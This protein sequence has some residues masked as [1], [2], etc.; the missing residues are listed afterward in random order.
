MCHPLHA[1]E[2]ARI[3]RFKAGLVERKPAK[4][5]TRRDDFG[6][7]FRPQITVACQSPT[8]RC[9]LLYIADA[10]QRRET[11]RD[12]CS[13]YGFNFNRVSA[14]KHLPP[15]LRHRANEG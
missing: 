12:I 13:P 15:K 2:V 11:L 7:G 14:A 10:R 6:S 1:L 8:P 4:P 9:R 5:R 3:D